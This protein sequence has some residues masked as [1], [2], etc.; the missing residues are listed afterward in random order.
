MKMFKLAAVFAAA[1]ALCLSTLNLSMAEPVLQFKVGNHVD[2]SRGCKE[3]PAYYEFRTVLSDF[4][5]VAKRSGHSWRKL[6]DL[7]PS[8]SFKLRTW[9][10]ADFP[11]ASSYD[12]YQ[13]FVTPKAA[14]ILA[15]KRIKNPDPGSRKP[16]FSVCLLYWLDNDRAEQIFGITPYRLMKGRE[17]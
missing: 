6:P 12:A 8:Q 7:D 9:L 14:Y 2:N 15:G 13:G 1:L 4:A 10:V 16:M 3:N 17:L 11:S 5:I